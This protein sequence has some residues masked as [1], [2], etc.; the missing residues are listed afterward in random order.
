M[1][2]VAALAKA[3]ILQ[4]ARNKTAAGMALVL[5]LALGVMFLFS[6]TERDAAIALQLAAAQGL[7]VYVSVTTAFVAR[8]QDLSLKRLRSGELSDLAIVAG[9]LAPFAVLGVA[10]CAVLTAVAIA[11]GASVHPGLLVAI[12]GGVAVNAAA[13]VWT[14]A[15][16]ATAESAQITT[17]PFFMA[18]LGGV[19]WAQADETNLLPVALPGGA[20]ADLVRGANTWQAVGSLVVWTAFGWLAG[21]RNLRWDR[22]D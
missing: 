17:A 10:Q 1:N 3:E 7:T 8:R 14:A 5:P 16:T 20:V 19:I 21:L 2:P 6:V 22:R 15:F 13:G 18:G 9:V 12:I 4:L 11:A